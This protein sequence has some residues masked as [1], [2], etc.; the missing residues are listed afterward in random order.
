[1]ARPRCRKAL[2]FR[3]ALALAITASWLAG[4]AAP[5]SAAPAF[6]T[7]KSVDVSTY[8]ER[9]HVRCDK[10][11][12]GGFVFFAVSTSNSA[13]AARILAVLLVAHATGKSIEVEFDTGDTSGKAF[14]CQEHDCRRLISVGIK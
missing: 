8:P 12:A 4:T 6:H 11:A 5:V 7:C 1:M 9:I 10:A 3:L 14:G 2:V 13:H